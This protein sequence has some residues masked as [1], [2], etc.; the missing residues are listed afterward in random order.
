MGEPLPAAEPAIEGPSARRTRLLVVTSLYPTA[1][2]PEVGV[3]VARRVAALRERGVDVVVAAARSGRASAWRRHLEILRRALT[4]PG[5]FD[6]VEGHVAFPAGLIALPAARL[7][8]VPL[9]V[10]AHGEDITV[11]ARR[12]RLHALLARL[13]LRSAA[14]VVTNSAD[15]AG[16]I[17]ELG[18]TAAV[19]PPGVDMRAFHPSADGRAAARQ[20]LGLDDVPGL[21]AVYAGALIERKGADTFANA[22]EAADGW[23]GVLVGS[24]PLAA[25]LAERSPTVRQ[26]GAVD[27]DRMPDWFRA[28]DAVVVPSRREPLGLAAVEALACGTPV[29]ASDVGG[30]RDVVRDGV[31]GLS[32]PAGDAHAVT[33]ALGRLADPEVRRRLA[34]A[35]PGSVAAHDLRATS[36]AMAE[37]WARLGV[38]T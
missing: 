21:L 12:T 13:V 18:A 10:Y 31:N 25:S 26:V 30:L 34:S 9:L 38:R 19:I 14:A 23:T 5:R 29:V 1:E 37:I 27:P 24:G 2:R 20:A 28:A 32:V 4:A 3:F 11:A 8:R 16:R 36:G 22:V 35:A 7:R 15:M 33:A 17:A 6:G